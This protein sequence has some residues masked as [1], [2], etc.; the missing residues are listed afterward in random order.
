M[1]KNLIEF[2]TQ[3]EKIF[4]INLLDLN[5]Y[6]FND[7][8][9]FISINM[10][11]IYDRFGIKPDLYL[12]FKEKFNKQCL[13]NGHHCI[14]SENKNIILSSIVALC[15]DKRGYFI[16]VTGAEGRAGLHKVER[17]VYYD[18]LTSGKF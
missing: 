3:C 9:H 2:T 15:F 11:G 13:D 16:Y 17:D 1:N 4:T 5:Y 12:D 6:S 18:L 7:E 10:R 14:I 8:K